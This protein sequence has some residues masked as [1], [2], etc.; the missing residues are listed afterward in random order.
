MNE[1]HP[2]A[3][4]WE[5]RMDVV[6]RY[7]LIGNLR[8]VSEQTGVNY[9]SLIEWKKSDWWPE[10]VEQLRRQKKGK[11]NDSLTKIIEQSL[12][13]MQDR[14]ENGDF[15]LN[16]KTGEIVRKPVGVKEATAI[17]TG[18]IQRQLQLE[19][20]MDKTEKNSDTVAETLTLLAKEFQKWNKKQHRTGDIEE[21]GR[22]SCRERVSSPV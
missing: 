18:L 19:E 6:A 2:N 10:M 3:F 7:M 9:R 4:S 22:A 8:V 21:I 14:L 11:T 1:L 20:L 17:A 12:D 16:N 15:V 13:V 5:K